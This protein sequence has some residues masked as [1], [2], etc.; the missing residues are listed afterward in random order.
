MAKE[1]CKDSPS[2]RQPL[3]GEILP[4]QA[5]AEAGAAITINI[6]KRTRSRNYHNGPTYCII[7]RALYNAGYR[8][9]RVG[10]ENLSWATPSGRKFYKMSNIAERLSIQDFELQAFDS[11]IDFTQPIPVQWG[12]IIPND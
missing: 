7:Y 2:I 9:H 11:I 8:N 10:C 12:R 5:D 1:N 4:T 6:N 3:P